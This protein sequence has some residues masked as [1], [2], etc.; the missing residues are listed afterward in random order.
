[1]FENNRLL[2]SLDWSTDSKSEENF[3]SIINIFQVKNIVKEDTN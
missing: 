3:L 1:M 2:V